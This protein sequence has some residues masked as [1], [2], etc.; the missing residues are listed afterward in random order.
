MGGGDKL[1]FQIFQ[2]IFF[3]TAY[4]NWLVLGGVDGMGGQAVT[5]GVTCSTAGPTLPSW[6]RTRG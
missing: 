5:W 2:T 1:Y 6:V 3:L 4:W